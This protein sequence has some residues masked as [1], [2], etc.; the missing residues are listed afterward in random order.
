MTG[1]QLRFY[2]FFNITKDS[3][4]GTKYIFF[5]YFMKMHTKLTL[6]KD[7][8]KKISICTFCFLLSYEKH[9]GPKKLG[10]F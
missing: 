1:Y 2:K 8:Q 7:M 6:L 9:Q 4:L 10:M 5:L 3:G